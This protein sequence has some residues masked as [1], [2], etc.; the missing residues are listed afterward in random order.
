M[1]LKSKISV[2]WV[3]IGDFNYVLR[4]DERIK[5]TFRASEYS[6]LQDCMN[7]CG[8]DEMSSLGSFFSLGITSRRG[9]VECSA[10]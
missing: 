4:P 7:L 5:A 10:S 3:I 6:R 1:W 8:M 9:R 2:P